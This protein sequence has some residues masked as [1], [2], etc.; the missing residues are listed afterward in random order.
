MPITFDEQDWPRGT[1]DP[2]DPTRDH[3]PDCTC[4]AT[5]T[6]NEKLHGNRYNIKQGQ[7]HAPGQMRPAACEGEAAPSL[8]RW[9]NA[10]R[11]QTPSIH[12]LE[13]TA[14]ARGTAPK[15]KV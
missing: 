15:I 12:P 14:I 8:H 7:G 4:K 10:K 11:L 5:V 1:A 6:L 9:L 13:S 3:S 2:I